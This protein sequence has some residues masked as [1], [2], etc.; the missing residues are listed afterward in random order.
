MNNYA[1]TII[2]GGGFY[3]LYLA[4][5]FASKNHRVTLFEAEADLMSR[6]SYGNQ[7]R[8]HN[9]YHYP[10]STLTAVRSRENF[11]RFIKEFRPAIES[12]FEKIYAI[13]RRFS[14][15]S[16]KQFYESMKRIGAPISQAP[17]N[18]CSLFDKSY[19]EDVFL[20]KEHAF[21][22]SI[23]K[24]MMKDRLKTLG[25]DIHLKTSV[26]SLILSNPKNLEL[27]TTTEGNNYRWICRQA[28]CCAY[29]QLNSV[30]IG[31]GLTPIPLKHEIAE[32]ALVE[33]PKILS[34]IGVTIM[35]G[36]FFSLMPFPSKKL[37]S[38][39]HVRYTPHGHWYDGRGVY[40]P[41]YSL[42]ENFKKIT[43]YPH[44]IRDASRYI[45]VAKD[46]RYISS[47]WEVKTV[48]PR[49]ETDDSRPILFRPSYGLPNYHLVMG[50]KIDNIYDI[51]DV[52][53]LNFNFFN[54]GAK[55]E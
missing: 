14:K 35:D 42:L 34:G 33:V 6:A 49:S 27:E 45:P 40:K 47:I 50:G 39:S 13:G 7:A 11:P 10:R 32:I 37:H 25:V 23:L 3:G 24:E 41:A 12:N 48:L 20:T 9:G 54:A 31:A 29:S 44:M 55:N 43:A 15:V 53:N 36:P 8:V 21:N 19:V 22:S 4:D 1:D 30:G 38:L 18:I 46:T 28:F 26:T 2:I 51:L 16:S 17:K 52:I 5:F